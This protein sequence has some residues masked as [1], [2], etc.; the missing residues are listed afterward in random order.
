MQFKIPIGSGAYNKCKELGPRTIYYVFCSFTLGPKFVSTKG[1]RPAV[2]L[3]EYCYNTKF[4]LK[5]V[6]SDCS[7]CPICFEEFVV[8]NED[9]IFRVVAAVLHLGNIELAK[10]TERDS[11]EPKDEKSRFHLA[12][13]A[14]L[15]M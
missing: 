5:A 14:E 3:G 9:A 13:A 11:S 15:F 1:H 2:A 6:P 12:T 4:S 10:G 7:E 8:G